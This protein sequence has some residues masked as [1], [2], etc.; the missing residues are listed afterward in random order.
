MKNPVMISMSRNRASR[1]AAWLIVVLL[2]LAGCSHGTRVA[3]GV[4]WEHVTAPGVDY[5]VVRVDLREQSLRVLGSRPDAR[6]LTVSELGERI[7]AIAAIN[8]DYFEEDK[9]P[10]GL[11]MGSCEKWESAGSARRQWVLFVNGSRAEILHPESLDEPPP[12]WAENGVSGWPV[13]VE[14]CRVIPAA[15]LPGSDHF[16]RAP[17]PRTAVGL[18]RSGRTLYLVVADGRREGVP[19]LTLEELG[20]IMREH[21]ACEALNL[22]GGGS[23]ALFLTGEIRNVPSDGTERAVGNHLA[24]VPASTAPDC[25]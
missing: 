3:P 10:V 23:S 12:S 15:E 5:H 13:V 16:T 20:K 18:D 6:G 14:N 25:D 11:A 9:R 19:G 21:G 4:T 24:V 22:D 2:L 7:G 1:R 8:G 17:H